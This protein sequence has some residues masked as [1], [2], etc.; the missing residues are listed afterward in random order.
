MFLTPNHSIIFIVSQNCS[1][2]NRNRKTSRKRGPVFY[3]SPLWLL[4]N[5]ICDTTCYKRIISKQWLVTCIFMFFRKPPLFYHNYDNGI[6]TH[7]IRVKVLCAPITPYRKKTY[8][9]RIWTYT[10]R[11]RVCHATITPFRMGW[12]TGIEPATFGATIRC[13]SLLNY[14]HMAHPMGFE[15]IPNVLEGRCSIH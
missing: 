14:S 2:I 13:S 8:E 1:F 5:S 12:L 7:T 6:R 15:P 3:T 11:V 9:N 4:R 10:H